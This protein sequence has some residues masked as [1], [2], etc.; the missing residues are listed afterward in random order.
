[1]AGRKSISLQ[2][3]LLD[4]VKFDH[5]NRCWLFM[6][7][8]VKCR[9]PNVVGYGQ[10]ADATGRVTVA[11]R[12]SYELFCGPIPEGMQVCHKCDVRNCISPTHLFLG[13]GSENMQDAVAKRRH[14]H[15]EKHYKALLEEIEVIEIRQLLTQGVPNPVIAKRF[16]VPL[17]VI[18][19]IRCGKSWAHL[20]ALVLPRQRSRRRGR[21]IGVGAPSHDTALFPADAG[22]DSDVM[23]TLE[24]KAELADAMIVGRTF[25]SPVTRNS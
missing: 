10:M 22:T 7:A 16:N 6:G 24:N 2:D 25:S 13:T 9:N 18:Q 20:G 4:K 3:R 11:H 1:M 15:G 21:R 8:T 19:N 23:N 14:A 12:I 5:V 17:G